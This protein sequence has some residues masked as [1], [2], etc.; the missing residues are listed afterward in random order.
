MKKKLIA[1]ILN[2][3]ILIIKRIT[4]IKKVSLKNA[5]KEFLN[6]KFD[7]RIEASM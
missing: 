3:F 4:R 7:R 6:Y 1:A 2:D 5:Y